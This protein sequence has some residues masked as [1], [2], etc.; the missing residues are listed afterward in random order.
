V[1]KVSEMLQATWNKTKV[2]E[3]E[4]EMKGKGKGKGKEKEAGEAMDVS[5]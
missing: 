4:K 5:K 2:L 1:L 3:A